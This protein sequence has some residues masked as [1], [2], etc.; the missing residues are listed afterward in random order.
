MIRYRHIVSAIALAIC[1]AT[2]VSSAATPVA[3][4]TPAAKATPVATPGG[5]AD[6]LHAIP[7]ILSSIL[8]SPKATASPAPTPAQSSRASILTY[9]GQPIGWDLVNA[10]E[11]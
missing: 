3:S 6:Y 10:L 2:T 1:F 4:T 7:A 9:L 8:P 5:S 11:E